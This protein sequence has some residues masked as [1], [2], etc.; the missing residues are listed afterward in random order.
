MFFLIRRFFGIKSMKSLTS[1]L[2][3][4]PLSSQICTSLMVKVS[5]STSLIASER[6]TSIG[7]LDILDEV[8]EVATVFFP[9]EVIA[10]LARGGFI[11]V[12]ELRTILVEVV[13]SSTPFFAITFILSSLVFLIFFNS[14]IFGILT[15][16]FEIL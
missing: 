12:S 8:Q 13:Y 5:G 1:P 4:F 3:D 6:V 16:T 10:F 2:V 14:L 9:L 15:I 11:L 7:T